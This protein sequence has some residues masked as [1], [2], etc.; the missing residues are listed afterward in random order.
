MRKLLALYQFCRDSWVTFLEHTASEA[1]LKNAV[2]PMILEHS[3]TALQEHAFAMYSILSNLYDLSVLDEEWNMKIK[4]LLD[5]VQLHRLDADMMRRRVFADDMYNV[6]SVWNEHAAQLTPVN[7]DILSI[8]ER[9][10]EKTKFTLERA[11]GKI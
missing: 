7:P 11:N 5:D 2:A 9:L 1:A 6:L 3:P 4:P 10:K 8:Y